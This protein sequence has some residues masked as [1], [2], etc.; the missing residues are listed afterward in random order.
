MHNAVMDAEAVGI[1]T[2][3]RDRLSFFVVLEMIKMLN[4]KDFE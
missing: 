4:V 3:N 2:D 1:I